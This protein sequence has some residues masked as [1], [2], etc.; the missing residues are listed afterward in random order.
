MEFIYFTPHYFRI[1]KQLNLWLK[2]SLSLRQVSCLIQDW[3]WLGRF[4]EGHF[5]N[6]CPVSFFRYGMSRL[7]VFWGLFFYDGGIWMQFLAWQPTMEMFSLWH[8][9][10]KTVLDL[11]AVC[12]RFSNNRNSHWCGNRMFVLK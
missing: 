4:V 1:Q 5:N 9:L 11:A 6:D 3:S 8:V 2:K 10:L 7:P 12:S